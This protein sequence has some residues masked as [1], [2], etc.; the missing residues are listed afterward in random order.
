MGRPGKP[1]GMVARSRQSA[2]LRFTG[3]GGSG[4]GSHY[5]QSG[6]GREE[7]HIASIQ[8][9][10]AGHAKETVDRLCTATSPTLSRRILADLKVG[11]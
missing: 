5:P 8:S 4:L 7:Q 2:C 11:V 9:T 6:R 3:S 10:T 1:C